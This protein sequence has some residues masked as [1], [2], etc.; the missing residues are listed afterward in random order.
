MIKKIITS[1]TVL[2]TFY[3]YGQQPEIQ[4]YRPNSK[5]GLNTFEAPKKDTVDFDGVKV[6]VGGDFAMQFQGLTQSNEAENL[7]ELGSNFNLPTANLNIDVQLYDGLRMHMRTYMSSRHHVEAWIKGGHIQIDELN[8]IKKD[9]LSGLM[10]YTTVRIGLDEIN[11]GDAHFRR[12]DNAR[13]IYNPFVG[14]Y[15]MDAFTT[16]V[17]GEVMLRKK[18]VIGVL[19]VSNGKLNQNVVI[20]DN[21]YNKPS[22]YG[23]LGYDKQFGDDFRARLTGSWYINTG[24]TTGTWLYGGDRA[25]ARYYNILQ[26]TDG[27]G[28]DFDSRYNARFAKIT[29]FQV[30]PFIKWK[31]LELFGI[32]EIAQGHRTFENPEDKEGAMTQLAAELIYRFGK[33]EQFYVAG[34]YNEVSGKMR[35]SATDELNISRINA[36]AGWYITKNVLVKL[37]YV[38]QDYN[39]DAWT[40]R[41]EGANFSGFMGEAAISF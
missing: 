7:V 29:S 2:A 41:F 34:R 40:G 36:G 4:Y 24:T 13:A 15:I 25:G 1:I 11:Y 37:E 23:K 33:K 17:F 28:G 38:T 3:T 30:N 32:Y 16:E 20:D 27:Q 31:G 19:G 9:F 12:S 6:R 5:K 39:G 22:F 8:F 18:G 35:E 14:N 21:T 26:T 10:D